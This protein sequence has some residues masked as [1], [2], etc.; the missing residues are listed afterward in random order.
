MI[1]LYEVLSM[2]MAAIQMGCI[3]ILVTCFPIAFI[4]AAEKFCG[5]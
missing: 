5:W 3:A 1:E 2:L 4:E